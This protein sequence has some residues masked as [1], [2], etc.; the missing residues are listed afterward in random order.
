[1]YPIC[2]PFCFYRWVS[3]C[4]NLLQ[5]L[6]EAQGEAVQGKVL[7]RRDAGQVVAG[8]AVAHIDNYVAA[9]PSRCVLVV[10]FLGVSITLACAVGTLQRSK[11]PATTMGAGI[12]TVPWP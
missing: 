8:N 3:H 7:V 1:M 11:I 12:P 6:S 2:G 4:K 5:D 9:H 10:A